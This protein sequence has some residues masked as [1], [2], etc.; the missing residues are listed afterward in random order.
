M[1]NFGAGIL[2]H[3]FGSCKRYANDF[4]SKSNVFDHILILSLV[5]SESHYK[6]S[7]ASIETT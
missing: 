3:M 2:H 6:F 1:K 7:I 4:L 5:T